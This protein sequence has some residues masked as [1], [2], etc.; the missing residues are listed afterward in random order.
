MNE[1]CSM[2]SMAPLKIL[3]SSFIGHTCVSIV[4]VR[5]TCIALR[6]LSTCELTEVSTIRTRTW[7]PG[8]QFYHFQLK[9]AHEAC[10]SRQCRPDSHVPRA[11]LVPRL[12]VFFNPTERAGLQ[13]G[14]WAPE[15]RICRICLPVAAAERMAG[16]F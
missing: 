12:D 4:C 16:F 8:N 7:L 11:R 9:N 15:V 13:E 6:K 3:S 2:A 1:S 14:G 5:I 10:G